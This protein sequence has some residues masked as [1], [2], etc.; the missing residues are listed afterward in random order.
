M[1]VD[2]GGEVDSEAEAELGSSEETLE[3]VNHVSTKPFSSIVSCQLMKQQFPRRDGEI[4]EMCLLPGGDILVVSQKHS[5]NYRLETDTLETQTHIKLELLDNK[6]LNDKLYF[7]IYDHITVISL[8]KALFDRK[9][10]AIAISGTLDQNGAKE[11]INSIHLVSVTPV[12]EISAEIKLE[13][14]CEKISCFNNR[15][16]CYSPD[17]KRSRFIPCPGIDILDMSGDLLKTIQLFDTV[18]CFTPTKDGGVVYFGARKLNGNIFRSVSKDNVEVFLHQA[19]QYERQKYVYTDVEGN[20]ITF[21]ESGKVVLLN[22]DG[23]EKRV[24]LDTANIETTDAEAIEF[25]P[26]VNRWWGRPLRTPPEKPY[27]RVN[28]QPTSMCFSDDYNKIMLAGRINV[29]KFVYT[30]KVEYSE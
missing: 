2:E 15:I 29:T 23:S 8:D 22:P 30:F 26:R 16:Y 24:L 7:A 28:R 14:R 20:T 1:D 5:Q 27:I 6:T 21:T 25:D 9:R 11:E 12:L 17:L 4:T 3:G 18:S 10:V 19:P 13:Y